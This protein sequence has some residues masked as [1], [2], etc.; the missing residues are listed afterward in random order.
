[1]VRESSCPL[2]AGTLAWGIEVEGKLV[3]YITQIPT[4]PP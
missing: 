1:M 3:D 4:F 2:L